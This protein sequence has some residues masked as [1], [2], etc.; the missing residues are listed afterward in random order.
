MKF[1]YLIFPQISRESPAYMVVTWLP[2]SIA[3]ESIFNFFEVWPWSLRIRWLLAD[4]KISHWKVFIDF[5]KS[6]RIFHRKNLTK[7]TS[8]SH[9]SLKHLFIHVEIMNFQLLLFLS[10]TKIILILLF[11]IKFSFLDNQGFIFSTLNK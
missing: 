7:N 8:I 6:N 2:K 11:L 4:A 3:F 10:Q 1:E 9:L 5:E